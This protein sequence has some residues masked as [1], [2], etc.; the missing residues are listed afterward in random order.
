MHGTTIA[1]AGLGLVGGSLARDLTGAGARV[2]GGDTD[3]AAVAAALQAGALAGSFEIGSSDPIV[4]D[5]CVLAVPVQHAAAVLAT[6]RPRLAQVGA[7]TDVGSTKRGIVT[8]AALLGMAD[9]FVGAHPL[10]GDHRS[11][12]EASRTLLFR[13]ARVYLTP[14]DATARAALELVRRLWQRVGAVPEIVDAESHDR[15]LAWISHLPQ[16][17]VSALAGCL[18]DAGIARNH[19]GPG[20]RDT[21]RLA[22]SN[23]ALWTGISLDN[24]A[25]L[26]DALL[27]ARERIGELEDA[28]RRLDAAAVRSCFERA[29]QWHMQG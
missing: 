5:V 11:G 1:I 2:L 9:R 26:A 14:T 18:A 4:A 8:A 16:A 24:A 6:L 27:A 20:G 12:F 23:P 17:V 25:F 19:L 3:P 15:Q 7:I 28:V 10:A 22:G 29:H 13:D 21:L